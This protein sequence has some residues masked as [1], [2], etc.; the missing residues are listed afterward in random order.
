M[1]GPHPPHVGYGLVAEFAGRKKVAAAITQFN[2]HECHLAGG[3][4]LVRDPVNAARHSSTTRAFVVPLACCS[5]CID[6]IC[7][8]ADLIVLAATS[9]YTKR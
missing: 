8:H 3:I 4:Q 5:V 6:L 2:R 1:R 9:P 7:L